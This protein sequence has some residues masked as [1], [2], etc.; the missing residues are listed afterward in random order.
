MSDTVLKNKMISDYKHLH[1]IPET[2]FDLKKTA[3]YVKQRLSQMN[4]KFSDC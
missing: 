4:I 3:D 2:G 1:K